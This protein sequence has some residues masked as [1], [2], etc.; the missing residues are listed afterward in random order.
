MS[1]QL[2]FETV[3]NATLIVHDN[4]PLLVTDPWITGSAYFGSWGLAHEIPAEQTDAVRHCQYVWISHGHPDHLSGDSLAMLRDKAILVPNHRGSRVFD[5]L[6][7]Q[8]FDVRVLPDREW[9]ALTPRVRVLCIPDYNQD[10]ILLVDID[11]RL[12]LDLNDA[13]DRGWGTFVR[14]LARGYSR[15]FLLSLVGRG[16][17]LMNYYGED[18]RRLPEP[19]KTPL[20]ATL[21]NRAAYWGATTAIP[22][23]A[24]HRFQRTDSAWAEPYTSKVEEYPEGF[25]DRRCEL[26]P[27]YVRYDCL[28]DEVV[29]L[30]PAR[31]TGPLHRPEEFGDHWT[32]PLDAKEKAALRSY[33]RQFEA[34]ARTIDFLRFLVG[35]DETVVELRPADFRRGLTFE[36]PRG[37]LLTA[38]KYEIFD[39]LLIGNFMKVTLHGEWGPGRLYPDFSPWVAK[40]GDNGR[41]HTLKELREYHR[42]YFRRAPGDY[43]RHR[44]AVDFLMPLQEATASALR[45]RL[46]ANSAVFRRAKDA[47]WSVRARLF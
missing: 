16:A 5:D 42:S 40:Y 46:G 35:G 1:F 45:S 22:F 19:P 11:G 9:V 10:A 3:G 28:T 38:L 31:C 29:P 34:L 7:G 47:Y 20:G 17:D 36:V 25:D 15:S 8:G 23:S 21:S 32:E 39:D 30:Q 2:G 14:N 33:F 43:L 44:V 26:L 6:K 4:T 24:M 13:G 41:A 37:S 27:A 12:V 18:G